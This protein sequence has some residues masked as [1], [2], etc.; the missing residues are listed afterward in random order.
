MKKLRKIS[1]GA[2][3]LFFNILTERPALAE[4]P[5][6]ATNLRSLLRNRLLGI[7][8]PRVRLGSILGMLCA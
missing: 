8:S 4:P 6:S 7:R 5:Y 3:Q 2:F 1:S